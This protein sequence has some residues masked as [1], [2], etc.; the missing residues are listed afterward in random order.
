MARTTAASV[1]R[2]ILEVKQRLPS[3]VWIVALN[4]RMNRTEID[5]KPFELMGDFP[6]VYMS[7]EKP[8]IKSHTEKFT[9]PLYYNGGRNW[10]N[11]TGNL[12]EIIKWGLKYD[13]NIGE[14]IYLNNVVLAQ[15]PSDYVSEDIDSSTPLDN[16]NQIYD[17]IPLS[18]FYFMGTDKFVNVDLGKLSPN[19]CTK[20]A[21]LVRI[22]LTKTKRAKGNL[23]KRRDVRCWI[24]KKM[25][26]I[27]G[28]QLRNPTPEYIKSLMPDL[29]NA[30]LIQIRECTGEYAMPSTFNAES[31]RRMGVH[32]DEN[33]CSD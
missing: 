32:S 18:F 15:I 25:P 12:E 7:A 21:D 23:I 28:K 4:V 9:F 3:N 10:N 1:I 2:D 27:E 29:W 5:D 13:P 22:E 31:C 8:Y 16:D 17:G 30:N 11:F 14:K 20:T 6:M 26:V 24:T 33:I 19:T